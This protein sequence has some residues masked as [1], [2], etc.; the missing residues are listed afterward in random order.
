M[1][2]R[3]HISLESMRTQVRSLGLLSG[4]GIWRCRELWCRPAATALF[5]PLAWELSYATGAALKRLIIIVVVVVPHGYFENLT[6]Y[7]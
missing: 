7:I 5:Q 2:Q 4:L 3:K 1:A 6:Y